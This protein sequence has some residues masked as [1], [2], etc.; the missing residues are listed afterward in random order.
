MKTKTLVFFIFAALI[1]N[2]CNVGAKKDLLSG[3]KVTNSGLSYKEAFL[4]MDTVKLTTSE[5]P[6]GKDVVMEVDGTEGFVEK[7]GK[8]YLGAS[9]DIFD[10]DGKKVM[11]NPD[12][13]ANYDAEGLAK[14][15]VAV[16]TLTLTV[17]SPLVSGSKYTWKSKIWDKNGKGVINAETEFT[18]K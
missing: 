5:F 14:E 18:V 8:V 9:L 17:G 2:A 11:D 15:Q 3:L 13:F 12:L 1:L 10:K 7:D 6:I 16:L 4:Y